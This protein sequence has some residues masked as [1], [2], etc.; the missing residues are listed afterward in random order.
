MMRLL[1]VGWLL[2]GLLLLGSLLLCGP[3]FGVLFAGAQAAQGGQCSPLEYFGRDT[4]SWLAIT[5]ALI[6][7][8]VLVLGVLPILWLLSVARAAVHRQVGWIVGLSLPAVAALVVFGVIRLAPASFAST[9]L[10][11]LML[12]LMLAAFLLTLAYPW[13]RGGGASQPGAD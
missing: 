7:L 10:V 8:A 11:L 6:V 12:L 9:L 3:L 4:C 1:R 13:D 2:A 5:P